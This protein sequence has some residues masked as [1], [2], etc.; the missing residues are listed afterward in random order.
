VQRK[1]ENKY[2]D[3]DIRGILVGSNFENA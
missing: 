2:P 3:V 1:E